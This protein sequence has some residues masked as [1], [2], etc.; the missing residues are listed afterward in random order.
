M[1]VVGLAH[2]QD[3]CLGFI[4]QLVPCDPGI[5]MQ[6]LPL[7]TC[8]TWGPGQGFDLLMGIGLQISN[9]AVQVVCTRIK[10]VLGIFQDIM[11]I[12]LL[13]DGSCTGAVRSPLWCVLGIVVGS[14]QEQQVTICVIWHW[15]TM[16]CLQ[17]VS[18][19]LDLSKIL[20]GVHHI[21]EHVHLLAIVEVG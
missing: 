20:Q 13:L 4:W 14:G 10:E 18:L 12:D 16:V 3:D 17:L 21:L 6:V 8:Q 15:A 11:G 7:L 1:P 5:W 2:T 19:I 9:A